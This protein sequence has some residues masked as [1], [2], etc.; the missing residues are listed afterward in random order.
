MVAYLGG[1][2][3]RFQSE[4]VA[5]TTHRYSPIRFSL[6]H[7]QAGAGGSK[8][9][10]GVS[11]LLPTSPWLQEPS[12]P[13]GPSHLP[14]PE[15]P[16]PAG[17][18]TDGAGPLLSGPTH[19]GSAG[20]GGRPPANQPGTEQQPA[21]PGSPCRSQQRQTLRRAQLCPPQP[22]FPCFPS[23]APGVAGAGSALAPSDRAPAWDPGSQYWEC[24]RTALASG[25]AEHQ[26]A[27]GSPGLPPWAA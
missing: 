20:A 26:S 12:T 7:P 25:S 9:L 27:G 13:A 16:P 6:P 1:D 11:V 21:S 5:M 2:S 22:F 3:A 18:T 19:T 24:L 15:P 14:Q 10:S 17:P 8:G 4:P 23:P